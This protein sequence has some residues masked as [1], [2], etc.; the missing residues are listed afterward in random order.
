MLYA[1]A[2]TAFLVI[3]TMEPL[4][5]GCFVLSKGVIAPR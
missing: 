1:R 2:K 5:Y 3:Q 4:P